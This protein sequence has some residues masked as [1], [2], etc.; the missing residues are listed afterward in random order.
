MIR[1][2]VVTATRTLK[3]NAGHTAINVL[4]LAV[5]LAACLLIGRYVA[6]AWRFD[7]FHA[8]ADRIVRVTSHINVDGDPM[9]LTTAQGPLAPTLEAEVP[10]VEA[11]ARFISGGYLLQRGTTQVQVGD[12]LYADPSLFDVFSFELLQGDPATALDAPNS[13]VVTPELARQLFG[14]DD[15]MGQTLQTDDGPTLTVTGVIAAPPPTSHIDFPALVS[16]ATRRAYDVDRFESWSRFSFWTYVLLQSETA[17]ESFAA[18]LPGLLERHVSKGFQQA[19]SYEVTPLTDVYLGGNSLSPGLFPIGPTGDPTALRIFLA[20]AVFILLIAGINFVNLATAR[21]VERAREVGVRKTLGAAR[22]ALVGQFLAEAVLTALLAL[23]FALMLARLALPIFHTL[24]GTTLAGGLIPSA[25]VAVA[26]VAAAIGVGLAAGAYP[27][28]VLA[29]Y[30]PARVLR[31]SFSTSREG[32]TLRQGLVVAQFAI[33]IALI[34]STGVVRQQLSYVQHRD[35][36]IAAEQ[37]VAI[38]FNQDEAVNRQIETIKREMTQLPGVQ[39][40]T[41]S[42]YVPGAGHDVTGFEVEAPNGQMQNTKANRFDVDFDFADAYSIEAIAGRTVSADFATDSTQAVMVNAAAARHFGYADPAT[43]VGKRV[44]QDDS[45]PVPYIIVGVV[46]DF[47]YGSLHE[48]VEPLVI[49]PLTSRYTGPA[50]FLT[51]RVQTE[52]LSATMDAVQDR[53]ASLAPDRP[54]DATFVDQYFARL[55]EQDRQF[56]RLFAAFAALAIFVACLGLFGLATHTVQQRTKEIG[57][58]KALG[59]SAAS[60]AAL[61]SSDFAKL[62]GIAFVVAVPAA[63]LGMTRWLE[64]FAYRIDLGAGV[65]V[66]AGA[67][68]FV[69]AL[70]TVGVQAWRAARLDPTKALRSE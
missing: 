1:N 33:A 40:A 16:M 17:P 8:H 50:R 25:T 5:G 12:L 4:G 58:R 31:G 66:A 62:V 41:A 9:H 21:A 28:L 2:Y 37:L 56:G 14:P 27:A 22:G 70:G 30:Q 43:A 47:H 20:V 46:E 59:A 64:S 39:A 10:G 45:Q 69:V 15:P 61:L 19:L 52:N 63:Y 18:Q 13:I 65:F 54:Y 67:L 24:A 11:T 48:T 38:N 60:L 6:D 32:Q 36:G 35:L 42:V 34:A 23:G 7:Q 53:W 26:L 68:A 44:Q 49:V 3:R 57:I 29:G 51:L 55:Y